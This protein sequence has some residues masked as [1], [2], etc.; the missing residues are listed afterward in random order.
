ME[1][2]QIILLAV[3]V[4]AGLGLFFGVL[5]AVAAK[6]FHVEEDN[7]IDEVEKMLPGA[8]CGACGYPGCRG[9]AEAL[10]KGEV[11]KCS[12]CKVGK[13]DKN[14]NP[15]I[16]YMASHPDPDGTERKLTL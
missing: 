1:G 6:F 3:A 8:N 5:L 14:F 2:W 12:A 11:T 7:R 13:P 10:V 9:L 16:E 4:L 15:I